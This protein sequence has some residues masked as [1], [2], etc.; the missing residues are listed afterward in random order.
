MIASY[1]YYKCSLYDNIA[2]YLKLSTIEISLKI[3]QIDLCHIA[4]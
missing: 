4:C 2:M 1:I 3:N